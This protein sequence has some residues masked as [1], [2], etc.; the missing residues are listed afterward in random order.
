MIKFA[1][2]NKNIKWAAPPE[3]YKFACS[4]KNFILSEWKRAALPKPFR[5]FPHYKNIKWA[6]PLKSINLCVQIKILS[7]N[8]SSPPTKSANS[9][10]IKI[11]MW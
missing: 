10:A 4:D 9:H 6:A 1:Y 3:I 7:M 5:K 11:F 8:A 2:S